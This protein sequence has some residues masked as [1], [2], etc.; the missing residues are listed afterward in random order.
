MLLEKDESCGP[1]LGFGTNRVFISS[2]PSFAAS[3][4]TVPNRSTLPG[5]CAPLALMHP[6]SDW[7]LGCSAAAQLHRRRR[8]ARR[9]T[10]AAGQSS[11]PLQSARIRVC[12]LVFGGGGVMF[13]EGIL[14]GIPLGALDGRSMAEGGV[15]CPVPGPWG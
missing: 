3:V 11:A 13:L 6:R 2:E 10:P 5:S 12:V 8:K 9:A 1:P 4:D 14:E 7:P 15:H